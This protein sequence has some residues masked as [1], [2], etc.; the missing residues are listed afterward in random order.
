M[1]LILQTQLMKDLAVIRCRGRIV[2][3]VEV[4]ALQ[5][6]LDHQTEL[7]KKIILNLAEADFLD[8]SGLGTLVRVL[9]VLRAAGGDLK[10]C[11]LLPSVSRVLQITNLHMVFSTYPSER[12]AIEAFSGGQRSHQTPMEPSTTKIL[13]VDISR[14]LLA[15]LSALLK[16]AGY[17]VFTSRYLGEAMTLVSVIRPNVV[18]CGAGIPDLPTGKVALEKLRQN[19]PGI[20]VLHLSSEFSA[21]EA[22]HAGV[23]LLNRLQSLLTA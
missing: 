19:G 8:S 13:C 4:D 5:A 14:D 7:I 12:E 15:Y 16:R 9:S 22:G 18:I 10:L 11:E 2:L 6:E 21:A 17:E 1:R 20:Q 23:D 3:G